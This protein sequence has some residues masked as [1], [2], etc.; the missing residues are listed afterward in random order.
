[1]RTIE[2]LKEL[3]V[4]LKGSGQAADIPGD[5]IPEVIEQITAAYVES[6]SSDTDPEGA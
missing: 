6:K 4:A 5:T 3:A 1:M 2:A